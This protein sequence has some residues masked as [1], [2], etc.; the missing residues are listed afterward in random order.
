MRL[1]KVEVDNERLGVLCAAYELGLSHFAEIVAEEP[2]LSCSFRA[3][4]KQKIVD[5][6]SGAGVGTKGK[7]EFRKLSVVSSIYVLLPW[8]LVLTHDFLPTIR[9]GPACVV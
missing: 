3:C 7:H 9:S 2:R 5:V 1:A 6:A 4:E 8:E